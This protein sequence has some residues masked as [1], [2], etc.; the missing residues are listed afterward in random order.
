MERDFKGIWIPK[1]I[2]LSKELNITEKILLSV[3][4]DD[5]IKFKTK[6][7]EADF[8]GISVSRHSE[9]ISQLSKKGFIRKNNLTYEKI[10][11]KVIS[12]KNKGYVS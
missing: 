9:L 7:E 2:W 12:N 8:F 1:E 11:D 4:N 5:K 3:I 6:K 10:K